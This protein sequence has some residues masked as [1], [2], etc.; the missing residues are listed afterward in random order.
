MKLDDK[1]LLAVLFTLLVITVVVRFGL[2]GSS[3][4]ATVAPSE[5]IPQA[6][7]RLQLLRQKV[8]TVPGRE[9]IFKK[10]AAELDAREKGILRADTKAQAQ[11]QLLQVTQAVAQANGIEIHGME[12]AHDRSLTPDYGEVSVTVG[13]TCAIEQLVNFLAALADQPQILATDDIR[14][15]GGNDKKKNIQVRLSVAAVVP[16]KLVQTEKKGTA[17]F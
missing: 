4:P 15:A 16:H 17:A 1:R 11:A 9:T 5:T 14:V 7:A 10:A 12:E 13:F 2:G 6:E 3:A 8:A